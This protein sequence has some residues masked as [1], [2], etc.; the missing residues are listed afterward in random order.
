MSQ[1][2][3][4]LLLLIVLLFL[5]P[6]TYSQT[7]TWS[8]YTGF[9]IPFGSNSVNGGYYFT[10]QNC[11]SPLINPTLVISVDGHVIA[12]DLCSTPNGGWL[13]P[14]YT[15]TFTEG[16]HTVI[17][18]LL[19]V[20]P[21]YGDCY[22]FI[23]W[24]Q[25]QFTATVSFAV[26]VQ[27]NFPGG[28]IHVNSLYY[29]VSSP[30]DRYSLPTNNFQI[31]AIEQSDGT[32]NRIWNTS[33]TNNSQWD[34]QLYNL[35][36]TF[37]SYSQNTT[38]TVQSNDR[39][40]RLI[41]GLRKVLSIGFQNNFVSVGNGGTIIVNGIQYNSPANGF[42]VVE[43]NPITATAQS[44]TINGIDYN[45]TSWSDGSTQNPRT[46]NPA[47][48][49]TIS[50][51]FTG[52][53]NIVG[54]NLHFNAS[55][56]NQ[57]IT[58]LWNEHPNTNVTQY[59]IWRKVNYKKQG[60]SSPVLIG[61][62]N[63]GTTSFVDYDYSGTNLGYTDYMLWYDVKPYY[64]IESTV[65]VD[66]YVC[67][68]SNGM[69]AKQ[70][71]NNTGNLTESVLENKMENYPNPFNPST[72]IT[73]QIVN[74]GHVSLKVYD[75]LGKEIAELVNEDLNSGKYNVIFNVDNLASGIYFY[76]IVANGYVETKKMIRMK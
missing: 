25:Q 65:S 54:R 4:K 40:T 45:F 39:N 15:I 72:V 42:M 6:E 20:D 67:V 33:G 43:Q 16:T 34:R 59:Q 62:V 14:S 61:T 41:A 50:A 24:Q 10:Y 17:F 27:N 32:Y 44:Q 70:G 52:K 49:S 37:Y 23:N 66:N 63:R 76:R 46:F 12:Y 5:I 75:C 47:D 30:N 18:R 2:K 21:N 22:H 69:L 9:N 3:F 58:V 19:S 64:S 55:N 35:N 51:N 74:Q 60:I 1:L 13:P 56:P 11:G 71:K 28:N 36:P 53:P 38:Y 26:R 29:T 8:G 7:F 68:F 48:N 57:P 31:G 73:Y